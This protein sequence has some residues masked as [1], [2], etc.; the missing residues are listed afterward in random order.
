VRR[1]LLLACLAACQGEPPGAR[2]QWTVTVRTD[3]PVPQFGDRLLVEVIDDSGTCEGCRRIFDVGASDRWPLTF[4]VVAPPS[5]RAP[6]VRVRFHRTAGSG[7][8]GTPT[9]EGIDAVGRL[10]AAS[11]VT[12][13]AIDL[14]MD[15]FG[16]ASDLAAGETCDPTARALAPEPVLGAAST[17]LEV[18]TWEGARTTPCDDDAPAP[19]GMICIPGGAFLLGAP[20]DFPTSDELLPYPEHVVRVSRFAIDEDEVTVGVMRELVRTK[21]VPAPVPRT[22]TP[23]GELCTYLGPDDPSN[24]ALP[25]NCLSW[26]TAKQ[27]C[28][29]LGKRLPTEAEWE[30]AAGNQEAE[31]TYP[32]GENEDVCAHARV[33]T[34]RSLEPTRCITP[35]APPGVVRGDS[36]K[37]LTA[38]GVRNLA[39]NLVEW[40]LD[41][42]SGYASGCWKR[43]GAL[44]DP[45]CRDPGPHAIRGSGWKSDV[46]QAKSYT[47]DAAVHDGP[48]DSI[49]FRC[50]RPL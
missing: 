27:A 39:G 46:R 32:W 9:R 43:E 50:A 14:R 28:E 48:V 12:R 42:F 35:G 45:V 19:R 11:G 36:T 31:T 37:D 47:R 3:A 21:G 13:V 1:A 38:R 44:L 26:P 41:S 33:A 8:D 4:G 23:I 40:T 22:T 7:T 17:P 29:A 6:R 18:G 16:V 2:P 10:P 49:G 34:G 20:H 5:G 30:W 24:D 25:V 15:C